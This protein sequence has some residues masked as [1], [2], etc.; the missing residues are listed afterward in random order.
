MNSVVHSDMRAGTEVEWIKAEIG[1]ERY[2]AITGATPTA[3]WAY[4]KIKWLIDNQPA[5][6]EKVHL[7]LNGRS[8]FCASWGPKT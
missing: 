8:T 1:A 6:F 3:I 5:L 4:P 2:A 7:L